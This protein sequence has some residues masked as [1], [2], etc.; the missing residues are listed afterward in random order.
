MT[1][2][3]ASTAEVRPNGSFVQFLT[4]RLAGEEYGVDILRVQE[5]RGWTPVTRIP[6]LPEYIEGVLNLRG[7]VV[8]IIDLRSRF[9]IERIEHGAGTVIVVLKTVLADRTR[10]VG[11]V[12]DGVS[13]VCNVYGEQLKPAP[14]LGGAVDVRFLKGMAAIDDKMVILLDVDRLLGGADAAALD[15][16]GG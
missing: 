8:P 10:T 9:G 15:K 14:D 2:A 13:D 11:L 4:F 3:K 12:V 6:G 7:S 1:Q 5:I 16:V